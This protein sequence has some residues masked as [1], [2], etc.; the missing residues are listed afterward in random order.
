MNK[1]LVIVVRCALQSFEDKKVIC[2]SDWTVLKLKEYL[3]DVCDERPLPEKQRLIYSGKC[4]EDNHAN[5]AQV[6]GPLPETVKVYTIHLVYSPTADQIR[7]RRLVKAASEAT[8][9]E[10]VHLRQRRHAEPRES[11]NSSNWAQSNIS[12]PHVSV[13]NFNRAGPAFSATAVSAEIPGQMGPN[14]WLGAYQQMYTTYMTNYMNYLQQM[15]ASGYPLASQFPPFNYG[16]PVPAQTSTPSTVTSAAAAG[17]SFQASQPTRARIEPEAQRQAQQQA[18]PPAHP[19]PAAREQAAPEQA[20]EQPQ[21]PAARPGGPQIMNVGIGGGNAAP[22]PNR[23]LDWLEMIYMSVRLGLLLLLLYSYSSLEKCLLI[24]IVI[25]AVYGF[26]QGWFN[27]RGGGGPGQNAQE[28]VNPPQEEIDPRVE[29][30][31]ENGN[32]ARNENGNAEEQEESAWEVFWST[33]YTFITSFFASMVPERAP[34][35]PNIN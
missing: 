10:N 11:D 6:L 31:R 23:D 5:L 34:A 2:P 8:L 17:P 4:L 19:A 29:N 26:N 7:A 33:C 15:Y 16:F 28:Q 21:E 27:L 25:G 24:L 9:A 3:R 1:D 22:E 30:E 32:G 18:A 35:P 12:Q 13:A 20:V 14:D